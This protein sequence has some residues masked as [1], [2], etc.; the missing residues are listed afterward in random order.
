MNRGEVSCK[1]MLFQKTGTDAAVDQINPL[2]P[3]FRGTCA[4]NNFLIFN[5]SPKNSE[6]ILFVRILNGVDDPNDDL[7]GWHH[8][9]VRIFPFFFLFCHQQNIIKQP[10]RA[11]ARFLCIIKHFLKYSLFDQPSSLMRKID[12]LF[13][14]EAIFRKGRGK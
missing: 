7:V 8:C 11:S 5:I 6:S 13:K 14:N 9:L 12:V 1:K 10:N 4:N 3:F 2:G